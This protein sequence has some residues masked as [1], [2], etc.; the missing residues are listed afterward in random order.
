MVVVENGKMV[1]KKIAKLNL[2]VDHRFADG[3]DVASHLPRLLD[4]L[5]NP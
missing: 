1:V 4:V 3:A 5:E 2:W